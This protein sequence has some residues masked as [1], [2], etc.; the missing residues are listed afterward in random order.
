MDAIAPI[1]EVL[2]YDKAR[3]L[4]P[5]KHGIRRREGAQTPVY[6]A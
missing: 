5:E 2:N 4:D 3:A 6:E 1:S